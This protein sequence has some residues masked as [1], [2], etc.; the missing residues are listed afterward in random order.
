MKAISAIPQEWRKLVKRAPANDDQTLAPSTLVYLMHTD[1]PA[2]IIR[3]CLSR[4]RCAIPKHKLDKWNEELVTDIELESWLENIANSNKVCRATRLKRFTYRF[5]I[6]DQLTN[7]RLYKMKLK[8]SKL[9][10]L[11]KTCSAGQA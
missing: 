4:Q 6:R 3:R 10:Y 9:C 8:Q 7:N 1:K 2:T 5:N 11:C